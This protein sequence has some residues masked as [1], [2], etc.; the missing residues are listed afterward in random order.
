MVVMV[1]YTKVLLLI[2]YKNI[3]IHNIVKNNRRGYYYMLNEFITN[4]LVTAMTTEAIKKSVGAIIDKWVQP[5]LEDIKVR[6]NI[7]S[8]LESSFIEVFNDYLVRTYEQ[9]KFVNVIALGNNQV[10]I[11]QIYQPLKISSETYGENYYIT[12]YDSGLFNT[13]KKVI[14]EDSA[15]MGKSTI[16]KKLFISCIEKNEGI[17]IFIE[18]RKLQE[19]TDIVDL[20]ITQLNSI[21]KEHDK[22]LVL[23]IINRGDFIFFLD[24][25]DEIPFEYKDKI[26]HKLKEFIA[27]SNNNIFLLT[28]RN[29]NVLSS[30]GQFKKF[31]INGMQ[32]NEACEMIEKYD[33]ILG[34]NL[35]DSIIKQIN[36]N[37]EQDAFKDLVEFL[38]VPFLVSLIYLTYKHKRDVPVKKD[39]FYRKVYDALFEEHDLS[40]DGYKRQKYSGLSTDQLHKL[41]RK[42]GFICL[43]ENRIEYNKDKLLSLI[44]KSIDSPYFENVKPHDVFQDLIYNVPLFIEEGF[45]YRWSH[46]SFMEYFAANFIFID[47]GDRKEEILEGIMKS[48]RVPIYLNI[49]DLYYDIDQENF[50]KVIIYPILEDYINYIGDITQYKSEMER[51]YKEFMYKKIIIIQKMYTGY[52]IWDGIRMLKERYSVDNDF[53][54]EISHVQSVGENREL[55]LFGETTSVLDLF[56]LLKNKKSNIMKKFSFDPECMVAE[57]DKDIHI[58]SY[59]D[60]SLNESEIKENIT[61]ISN[62]GYIRYKNLNYYL[63]YEKCLEYKKRIELEI[64]KRNNDTIFSDF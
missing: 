2:Q 12:D 5:K 25:F 9:N 3:F 6:R 7:D 29:D 1:K 15:G 28:S 36:E 27:K 41:L 33:R 31:H 61:Y 39:Q 64:E 63:D 17:P 32:Y 42:L 46:K 51:F 58:I 13:Y 34:F 37:L 47:N 48:K 44:E 55:G 21:H 38:E 56:L 57:V 16:M 35:S 60:V 53:F 26:V 59:L 43:K 11:D 22:Q 52:P 10:D 45:T 49:L 14:I 62:S 30:F 54:Y 23:E 8:Q 4:P 24:G 18:L 19:E 20:I 50:D 40:K